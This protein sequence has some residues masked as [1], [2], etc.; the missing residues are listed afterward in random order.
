MAPAS[1]GQVRLR[2]TNGG[3][4]D[5]VIEYNLLG[6]RRDE[7][8]LIDGLSRLLILVTSPEISP[9]IGTPIGA[10]R[11][12]NAARFNLRTP[13]NA[14]RTSSIAL[15][16]DVIPGLGDWVVSSM[17]GPDGGLADLISDPDQLS[18]F[19]RK[20]VTPVAHNSGTC[21]MGSFDD[22]MAVVDPHGRVHGIAGLRIADASVMPTVPRGNTNLP[23]LMVAEKISESILEG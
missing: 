14:A 3:R 17:G 19:I 1:R 11:H 16:L 8:R 4:P 5:C 15:L 12:A 18:D 21:R 6:D 7:E 10:S 22:P 2:P 20:N 13:Y 9:L 23:T